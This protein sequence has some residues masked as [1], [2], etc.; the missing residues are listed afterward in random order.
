MPR[1]RSKEP[2]QRGYPFI[3]KNTAQLGFCL[4]R[5]SLDLICHNTTVLSSEIWKTIFVRV[6][7]W[8]TK[9]TFC[10]GLPTFDSF[11]FLIDT[12]VWGW[13]LWF[14]VLLLSHVLLS[15]EGLSFSL[16]QAEG[17]PFVYDVALWEILNGFLASG[18]R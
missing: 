11:I 12:A 2:H 13:D 9:T 6:L 18:L 10:Y 8:C 3:L 4:A 16:V 1:P 17:L 14:S 7:V 5:R 15:G